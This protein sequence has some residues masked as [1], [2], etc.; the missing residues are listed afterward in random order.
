MESKV[1]SESVPRTPAN[2]RGL[3]LELLKEE[4]AHVISQNELEW[5]RGCESLLVRYHPTRREKLTALMSSLLLS[6][7]PNDLRRLLRIPN[8]DE[9]LVLSQ[10]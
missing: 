4:A 7:H 6:P 5:V 9:T 1:I 2:G 8:K 10:R 3:T